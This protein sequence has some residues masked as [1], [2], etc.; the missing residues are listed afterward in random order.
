MLKGMRRVLGDV[1][2]KLRRG[3]CPRALQSAMDKVLDPDDPVDANIRAALATALQGLLRSAEYTSEKGEITRTTLMRSDIVELTDE[4]VVIM[5]APCKNMHHL[6]GKTCPLV[7]GA[8]PDGDT[9]SVCAVREIRNML[10][11]DPTPPAVST[12][13]YP[14]FRCPHSN[15]P[16]RYQTI[17]AMV[18][19]LM[20]AVGENPDQFSSHSLRIGGATALF[21]A[22]ANETVIRTMGRW[23]LDIHRL[24][25]RACFEQCCEW[26]RR[27]G[28]TKVTDLAGMTFDE[29]DDY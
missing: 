15:K 3:V 6:G 18:K 25:V 9:S 22:G 27:A 21:A 20:G 14:L 19:R 28:P 24:Y 8:Q 13:Q 2:K 4:R 23:S 29:V 10:R 1:P 11:V 26:T 7:D 5:M 12:N 17:N 16:I